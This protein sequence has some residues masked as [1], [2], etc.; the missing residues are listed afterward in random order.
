MDKVIVVSLSHQ[1]IA[2]V[3]A[4]YRLNFQDAAEKLAKF[5]EDIGVDFIFD[6]T[7]ARCLSIAEAQREFQRKYEK[8]QF[9]VLNS[10][11]PGWVC[12]A[13]KTHGHLIPFL[14]RVKSPQQIMGTLIKKYWKL[15]NAIEK[16]VY[17]VT[18]MPCYDKKLEA[19]RSYFIDDETSVK[20]VDSVITPVELELMLTSQ[21]VDLSGL[22]NRKLNTLLKP[23]TEFANNPIKSHFGSGSGGFTDNVFRFAA[24]NLL[25]Q[26][27]LDK[28]LEYR[29]RRNKDFLEIELSSGDIKL[30]FAIVNGFRNIQTLVQRM[31]RKT[32]D[33]QFVEVM[34]CPSGCLNGGAQ[35]RPDAVEENLY[36]T[37]EQLYNSLEMSVVSLDKLSE[38]TDLVYN[39][40]LNDRVE[41]D[42]YTDFKAVPK[43]VNL[44]NMHW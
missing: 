25:D 37:A 34:A 8:K 9:P 29:T 28:P 15:H 4:K 41:I 12:Y 39:K 6:I 38:E 13:E 23:I 17:H 31:K 40:W 33:Y 14:S 10:S 3:A 19:S 5:F 18:V 21:C 22:N 1:S 26:Q 42:L 35:L 11:C 30:L 2:S 44:L 24:N 36:E 27:V 7:I 16:D 43:T 20:D 32:C